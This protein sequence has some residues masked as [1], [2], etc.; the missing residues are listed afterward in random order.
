MNL[1]TKESD[2]SMSL[3][4]LQYLKSIIKTGIDEYPLDDFY[5]I[6]KSNYI[7]N[8]WN[9]KTNLIPVKIDLK[10]MYNKDGITFNGAFNVYIKNHINNKYKV[11]KGKLA[12][13][14]Q[15]IQQKN[16]FRHLK[17]L[18]EILID[19]LINKQLTSFEFVIQ[20]E[21]VK[22][23]G[24][25]Y[26]IYFNL[27]LIRYYIN[28]DVLGIENKK[29][30]LKSFLKS[31]KTIINLIKQYYKVERI[32]LDLNIQYI[33]DIIKDNKR[34]LEFFAL[35]IENEVDKEYFEE[36]ISNANKLY[37]IQV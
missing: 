19:K 13:L 34:F 24:L 2:D 21:K 14:S 5:H 12:K 18:D 10:D 23:E 7:Y 37:S 33:E 1:Y 8:Q 15:I 20:S 9:E 32:D 28:N 29:K 4:N 22:F 27:L 31:N 3:N 25:I 26:R 6:L 17:E 11:F 36:E 16:N 30:I 35:Y